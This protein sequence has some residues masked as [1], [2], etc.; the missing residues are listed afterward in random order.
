MNMFLNFEPER[1]IQ[2]IEI[3]KAGERTL[4]ADELTMLKNKLLTAE[5]NPNIIRLARGEGR[6]GILNEIIADDNIIFNWG[7]KGQHAFHQ[8]SEFRD[9]LE[10][11]AADVSQMKRIVRIFKDDIKY[12]YNKGFYSH[13][14]RINTAD[15]LIEKIYDII[16][17]N[18]NSVSML[19]LIKDWL[20][21][22][23]H[24]AG[25][26][27]FKNISPWVSTT[28]GEKRYETAYFFG[29]GHI[30]YSKRRAGKNKRFVIFDTWVNNYEEH[31]T[32]E[33]TEYLINTFKSL[34]LP[35]YPDIHHEF[36]LKYAIYPHRLIGYYYFENNEMLYYR[37]N[38]H[39][40]EYMNSEDDFQIGNEIYI[41]QS[42]VN[43]P[44]T[45]PYRIIYS[46]IGN[47]FNVYDRR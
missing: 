26:A 14:E 22:F 11:G 16:D 25:A 1:M 8:Q 20:C 39:Y 29:M 23:L 43:F 9:F 31:Y 47:R 32:Y 19:L 34:G 38:P 37:I 13:R 5:R 24:T 4:D 41:D 12:R 27:D 17:N 33:R 46:R 40:L 2:G 36:M 21:T 35:W 15:D 42:D 3:A 6:I 44:T 18:S 7:F 30:P 45:N 28:S 10:P